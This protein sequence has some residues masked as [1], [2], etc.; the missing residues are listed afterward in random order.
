MRSVGVPPEVVKNAISVR[1]LDA[2]VLI[3]CIPAPPV[4]VASPPNEVEIAPKDIPDFL[5]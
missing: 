2:A 1:L 3:A 4:N 5:G